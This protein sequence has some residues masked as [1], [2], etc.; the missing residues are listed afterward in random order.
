MSYIDDSLGQGERVI[1]RAHVAWLYQVAARG[2]L[3][4][5]LALAI[6]LLLVLHDWTVVRLIAAVAVAGIG[7]AAFF[8]F[9]GPVWGTEI[10]ITNQRIIVK[11]GLFSHSS[12]EL[13]LSAVEGVDWEQGLIDRLVGSGRLI[14]SGTGNEDMRLPTI[15]DALSFRR[16]VQQAI[17]GARPRVG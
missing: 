17:S 1:A 7:I 10:A 2:T 12:A 4:V 5:S 8:K 3:A 13:Q 11:K 6:W 15:S 9:I 16:A 14:V